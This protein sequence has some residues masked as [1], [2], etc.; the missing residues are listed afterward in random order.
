MYPG[1]VSLL[2]RF[3]ES[4]KTV[5]VRL[6]RATPVETLDTYS[7]LWPDP[8]DRTRDAIHNALG[9]QTR[10]LGG[11]RGDWRCLTTAGF[12]QSLFVER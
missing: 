10:A 2:I 6:G 4:V 5:Q 8:D 12:P 9:D 1:S 11:L 3:G 7:L